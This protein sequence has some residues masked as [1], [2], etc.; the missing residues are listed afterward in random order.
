LFPIKRNKSKKC[1]KNKNYAYFTTG[2]AE[3]NVEKT[4]IDV[5]SPFCKI[6]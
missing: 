5:E 3:K 4:L 2:V 1:G 6:T